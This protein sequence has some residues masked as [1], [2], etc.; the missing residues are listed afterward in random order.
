MSAV[1]PRQED[2][3]I[4]FQNSHLLLL[5]NLLVIL[6]VGA[7]LLFFILITSNTED[8]LDFSLRMADRSCI[9]D[10]SG[11]YYDSRPSRP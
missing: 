9:V 10:L 3:I 4:G 11:R 8:R 2:N 1:R 7:S 5:K 6:L